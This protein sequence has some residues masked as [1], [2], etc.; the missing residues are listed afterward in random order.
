MKKSLLVLIVIIGSV[1]SSYSQ[2]EVGASLA[3][4]VSNVQVRGIDPNFVPNRDFIKSFRPSLD[5]VLPLDDNISVVTGIAYERRGFNVF[6]GQDVNFL[7]IS[8]PIGATAKTRITYIEVPLNMRFDIKTKKNVTPWVQAGANFGYAVA[9]DITTQLNLILNINVNRTDINVKSDNLTQ[10]D[11]APNVVI[12]LDIPYN[13]GFFVFSLGYE[14]SAQ[15]FIKD[16]VIGIETR[17]YGFTPSFGYR[18]AF[19]KVSKA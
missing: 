2:V 16:S 10:F 6:V 15:N 1:V 19:G 3:M 17:H 12:G 7:G 11:I 18:Y 13:R 4:N 14:H 9:G 8:V 5:L